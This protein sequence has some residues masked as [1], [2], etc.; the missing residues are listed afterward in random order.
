MLLPPSR[1]A[2]GIARLIICRSPMCRHRLANL[3]NH[4]HQHVD[5]E[6][7]ADLDQP[8]EI[9][10]YREWLRNDAPPCI[11]LKGGGDVLVKIIAPMGKDRG[12]TPRP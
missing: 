6:P 5:Q 1:T 10:W 7:V 3:G 12:L 4:V 11:M 8:A 9:A 2:N